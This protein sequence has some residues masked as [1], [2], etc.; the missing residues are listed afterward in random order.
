M[1][2][3]PSAGSADVW[4]LDVGSVV[5]GRNELV[6]LGLEERQRAESF[7]FRADRR[8]YTAAH[9]MLRRVLSSYLDV[10]PSSLAFGREPCPLCGKP[11]GRPVLVPSYELHFSLAHS[12][13]AVVVAVA[14]QRVGVDVE[15]DAE[16][17]VCALAA[18]MHADDAGRAG[19][20]LEVDRHDL[21]MSWWVRAEA[22]LK[23]TGEGIGHGVGG[24]PVL[25]GFPQWRAMPSSP[26]LGFPAQVGDPEHLVPAM[27]VRGSSLVSLPAPPGYQAAL[28]LAAAASPIRLTVRSSWSNAGRRARTDPAR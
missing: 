25:G 10:P 9:V 5:I 16:G 14:R 8:R 15:Q 1:L 28:A 24:F 2:P 6:E 11:S 3:V 23:C 20:L 4:W 13:D 19:T 17:C 27:P 18:D 7:V 21:I 22:V 26:P 12:G